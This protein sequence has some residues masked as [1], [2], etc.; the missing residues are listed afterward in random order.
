MLNSVTS[1]WNFTPGGSPSD[2]WDIAYD[3]WLGP[4][5]N[6]STCT[7]GFP[8]GGTEMMIW[9]DYQHCIGSSTT[10][11]TVSL[12]GS[13]WQLQVNTSGSWTYLAYLSLTPSAV[14]VNNLDILAFIHDAESRTLPGQPT[15]NDIDPSDYLYSIPAGIELRTG[16]IPFTS[17]SFS[18]AIQ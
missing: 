17:N 9:V 3:V 7:G 5:S 14:P 12:S 16:G 11:A 4:A 1:S 15:K 8:C 13:Q 18:V 10:V 6:P 2:A